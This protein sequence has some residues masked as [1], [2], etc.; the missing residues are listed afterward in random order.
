MSNNIF[1]ERG[2]MADKPNNYLLNGDCFELM[3]DIPSKSIDMILTDPPYWHKK[4]PGKPYSQRKQCNTDSKFSNSRL[5]NNN[6]KMMKDMSDFTDVEVNLLM[7]ELERV[8]KPLNAYLFCNETLLPYYAMWAE[9]NKHHFSVLVWEKPLSIINKNRFSQNI[10]FIVRIYDYGT[11]LN[12]IDKNEAYNRVKKAKPITG[13]AKLHPT[14]KP[15]EI[16]RDILNLSNRGGFVLD[17]FAGSNT[18]GVECFNLDIP[19]IGIEKDIDIYE[20]AKERMEKNILLRA[21]E[22]KTLFYNQLMFNQ[23][24]NSSKSRS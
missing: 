19:Y 12:R 7:N 16:I 21:N 18:T 11:G 24:E 13:K 1:F 2:Q 9:K 6:N 20:V 15:N 4:S 22:R 23:N 10:E 17:P 14:Q 3:K 5:Y 8:C